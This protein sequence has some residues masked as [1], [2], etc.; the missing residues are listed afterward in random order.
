[1]SERTDP[2]PLVE[3]T[4][5]GLVF[6]G[7]SVD[8]F[9]ARIDHDI[10]WLEDLPPAPHAAAQAH[11]H[12]PDF[13]DVLTSCDHMVMGRATYQKVHSM[14][15]WPYAPLQVIVLSSTLS[16]ELDHGVLVARCM[17]EVLDVLARRG[18][19]QVYIDGGRTVQS[20]LAAGLV[21]HVVVNH[22]PILVGE[23]IP[24][25]GTLPHD[26]HLV[27]HGSA[28]TDTGMVSSRYQVL[29]SAPH[30]AEGSA[31]RD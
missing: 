23:G 10:A 21:D 16:T 13:D 1:M 18:A 31:P 6:A 5:E 24:L 27:H 3:R 11:P 12:V 8:G 19:G 17:H 20:F 4:W 30:A 9:I 14:G 26:L 29:H 28:T 7:L 22:V 15:F 25:F 2:L